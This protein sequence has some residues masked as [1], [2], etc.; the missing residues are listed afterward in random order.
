M[1][2][3]DPDSS[4]GGCSKTRLPACPVGTTLTLFDSLT[5]LTSICSKTLNAHL[6]LRIAGH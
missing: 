4:S 1:E 5:Q 3:G 6:N 2:Y